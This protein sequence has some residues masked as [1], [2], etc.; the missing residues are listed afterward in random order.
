MFDIRVST[1]IEHRNQ[2]GYLCN[3]MGLLGDAVEIGTHRGDW[4]AD[5]LSQ[6]DGRKLWLIDQYKPTNDYPGDR[7]YDRAIAEALLGHEKERI[8]FIPE[9]SQLALKRFKDNSLSFGYIDGD[10]LARAV[11]PESWLL[12]DKLA[13]GGVIAWHD[14]DRGNPDVVKVIKEF[15]HEKNVTVWITSEYGFWSAY[16]VKQVVV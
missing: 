13:P 5:F 3:K 8:E 14:Y 6:W 11:K 2:F 10:H 15:S 9:H 7:S 1:E 16:A 4:A 12:W